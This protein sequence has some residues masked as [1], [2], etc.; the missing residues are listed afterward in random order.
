MSRPDVPDKFDVE[1]VEVPAQVRSVF[2]RR[3]YMYI[4]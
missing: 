2:P 3:N 1:L 4:L